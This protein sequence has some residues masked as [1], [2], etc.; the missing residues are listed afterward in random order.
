M[1]GL[2]EHRGAAQFA[3]RLHRAKARRLTWGRSAANPAHLGSVKVVESLALRSGFVPVYLDPVGGWWSWRPR[4]SSVSTVAPACRS[5]GGGARKTKDSR[6]PLSHYDK[7]RKFVPVI[8]SQRERFY[9][10]LTTQV[11][12]HQS[13]ESPGNSFCG[14]S[15]NWAS[16]FSP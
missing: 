9:L 7:M 14:R 2:I 10:G 8:R 1:N 13:V 3:N 16:P 12:P 11:A 6:R 15:R 5:R 4:Q